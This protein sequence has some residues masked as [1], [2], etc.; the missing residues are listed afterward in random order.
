VRKWAL[1]LIL[2][3]CVLGMYAQQYLPPNQRAGELSYQLVNGV[4]AD[5]SPNTYY[6]FTLKMVVEC[7]YLEPA[8]GLLFITNHDKPFDEAKHYEWRLDSASNRVH[9]SDPCIAFSYPPCYRVYYYSTDVQLDFNRN[10]YTIFYGDCCRNFF[11]NIRTDFNLSSLEGF[12]LQGGWAC[13]GD[14]P[15]LA[16]C[17]GY[18]YNSIVYLTNIPSRFKWLYNSSPVFNNNS[19]TVLYV[20]KNDTFSHVFSAI[21]PDGDSL[22]YSFSP[23]KVFYAMGV[24]GGSVAMQKNGNVQSI[25]YKGPNYTEQQQLGEGVEIDSKTGRMHGVL[26]DTG[27]FLVTVGVNEYRNGQ[28]VTL[29]PHTRDVVMKVF[30]CSTLPTPEAILPA[31]IN[32]CDALTVTLPN[33]STPYHPELYWDNNL[34]LWNLGDGDKSHLRY[35]VHTYDTGTYNLRLITMPGYHCADTAYSKLTVYPAVH[36]SFVV[37]GNGCTGL[38]VKFINTSSADIGSI[39]N[40][41]WYFVN[42]KDSTSF[43]SKLSTPIY[44]FTVP[45][46]TYAAILDVTTTKGCEARDT[47]LINV[48]Q[49][50]LPLTTHDTV[51]ATG[52]PYPLFAN[53]GYDTTGSNYVWSPAAGLD[54]PYSANPVATGTQ[55][56]TYK[57]Q[58]NNSFGCSLTDTVHIKYYTGPEIY[59]P[60]A[61]TPNGDGMND[62]FRPFPVGIQKL[63]FFRVYNRWGDLVYQT[64]AYLAGWDGR[65][66]GREAAAGTYIYEVRGKDLNNKTVFKKGTVLLLR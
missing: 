24:G 19:D 36:P 21:D 52:V 65:V 38:P 58:V 41:T 56:I 28:P 11:N 53:S 32:N 33:N 1:S 48:R 54:D 23:A 60:A 39:N 43:S 14:P 2:L 3:L 50:P 6:H 44:T 34:Y 13:G 40:L 7:Q 46:Q 17:G 62:I 9:V 59:I 45:N 22:V 8:L 37:K 18:V 31:L 30:D 4:N 42:L 20:C 10:G 63:E 66:N 64:Q 26:R 25:I 5:G 61:F 51:I 27:A 12:K 47:Q 15:V 29:T 57:V 35:P 16:P 49:S 55:E